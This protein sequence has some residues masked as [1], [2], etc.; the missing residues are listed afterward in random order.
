MIQLRIYFSDFLI[1][2]KRKMIRYKNITKK[3]LVFFFS[4]VRYFQQQK[5]ISGVWFTFV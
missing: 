3:S 5:L 2:E 1:L 4:E